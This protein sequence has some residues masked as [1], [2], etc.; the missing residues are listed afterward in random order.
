MRPLS[1]ALVLSLLPL[2]LRAQQTVDASASVANATATKAY[3]DLT[4]ARDK[5]KADSAP[6]V[7][8]LNS[9][10][11]GKEEKLAASKQLGEMRK[12]LQAPTAAFDKA[13]ATADW[14]KFDASKD[15]EL[16]KSGLMSA[17]RG[18]D[19]ALAVKACR[20]FLKLFPEERAADGVRGAALPNALIAHGDF[21]DARQALQTAIEGAKEGNKARALLTLGDLEAATGNLVVA[22]KRYDEAAAVGDKNSERY[23]S[24]RR[25]LIGKPAPDIDSKDWIGGAAAPLSGLKGK[26]VLVDF[27][28]TWCP[29]CRMVMP[30]LSEMY[31]ARKNDGLVVLGVTHFY[32]HGFMPNSNVDIASDGNNVSNITA[33]DFPAHVKQFRDVTKISYPFVF[34]TE[35][36]FK[37]YQVS[38][39]PTLA[40]VDREGKIALVTVGSGSEALLKCAVDRLLAAK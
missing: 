29:P 4:A 11:T 26:V 6:L 2:S 30:K 17:S 14:S 36:N 5:L 27:W 22:Q 15:G 16:L 40:V 33:A 38:G 18:E 3:A 8:K 7:E 10:E 31:A 21:D 23:V 13:F 12:V 39:I 35:Q 25:E 24:L 1:L 28:A 32:D 20:T 19:A 34:G 37:D 9:K